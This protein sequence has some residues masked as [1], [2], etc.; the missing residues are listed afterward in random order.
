MGKDKGIKQFSSV[1]RKNRLHQILLKTKG[2]QNT[3]TKPALSLYYLITKINFQTLARI[4]IN[5]N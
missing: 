3:I 4:L 1:T 2:L 5:D